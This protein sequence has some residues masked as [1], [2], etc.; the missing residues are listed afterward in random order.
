[1]SVQGLALPVSRGVANVKEK[2]LHKQLKKSVSDL[3]KQQ[4]WLQQCR[5]KASSDTARGRCPSI[6]NEN[7]QR[8]AHK[9]IKDL[10]REVDTKSRALARAR[11]ISSLH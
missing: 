3:N 4:V 11:Y 10:Q 1:M 2:K 9:Q 7:A 6:H 5:D 8:D